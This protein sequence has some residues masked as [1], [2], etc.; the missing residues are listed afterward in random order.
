MARPA[1]M[2]ARW[3]CSAIAI[4]RARLIARMAAQEQNHLKHF[5][6]LL[7]ERGVRP[8]LLQP[9]WR[10]AGHALGAATA[11]M[12]PQAAMACTAAVEDEID[13]HYSR[14]ACRARRR[15]AGAVRRDRRIPGGR[16]RASR[17]R[18]TGRRRGKL[19]LSLIV[20]HHP[21]WLSY[22]DRAFE[23]DLSHAR[24]PPRPLAALMATPALAQQP[25]VPAPEAAA[26]RAPGAGGGRNAEP[27]SARQPADRLWRRSLPGEHQRRDHRLRAAAR[28]RPL[29][30]PVQHARQSQRPGRRELGQSR[31]RAQLYRRAPASA[32]ARP[33]GRAA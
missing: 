7:A 33:P 10:V 11:L 25:G 6:A 17:H 20:F 12:S 21:G 2:P 19:R 30:G 22:C 28:G 13:L 8:T 31:H 29:S 24:C 4:P 23:E 15:R 26:A 9:F 1:S 3:R 5:D 16:A 14:A 27:R 18:H 32:A